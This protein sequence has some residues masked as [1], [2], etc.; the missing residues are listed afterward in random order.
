M[1][2]TEG[3]PKDVS[4]NEFCQNKGMPFHEFEKCYKNTLFLKEYLE[5]FLTHIIKGR[6]D[7]E[8]LIPATIGI[9]KQLKK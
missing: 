7:Y 3:Q 9:K 4:I 6:R 1:N 2:K 8:N 5:E